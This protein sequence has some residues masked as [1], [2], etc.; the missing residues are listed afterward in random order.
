MYRGLGS[1]GPW[2]DL[3]RRRQLPSG[4]VDSSLQLRRASALWLLGGSPGTLPCFSL[5]GVAGTTAL[6]PV[7]RVLWGPL[8]VYGSDLLHICP[9][10][11]GEGLWLLTHTIAYFYGETL[12]TQNAK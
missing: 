5:G 1:L 6:S 2:Q 3:L 8:D 7:V 10:S 11:R 4:P 9:R 12:Y